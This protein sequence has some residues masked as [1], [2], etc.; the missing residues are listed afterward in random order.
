[1]NENEE[2]FLTNLILRIQD[3]EVQEEFV[4]LIDGELQGRDYTVSPNDIDIDVLEGEI[5][6]SLDIL[7]S[8]NLASTIKFLESHK[9]E[10]L[11][12]VFLSQNINMHIL[13]EHAGLIKGVP[14]DP[15]KFGQKLAEYEKRI[16]GCYELGGYVEYANTVAYEAE[17]NLKRVRARVAKT[18]NKSL[19]SDPRK[20]KPLGTTAFKKVGARD[21]Y[22]CAYCNS[23]QELE[24]DHI[25][26]FSRG[27]SDK[28][29][30]LQLLCKDCNREKGTSN[31]SD[32]VKKAVSVKLMRKIISNASNQSYKNSAEHIEDVRRYK[33]LRGYQEGAPL[34]KD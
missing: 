6:F 5:K 25:V 19:A 32:A 17:V 3:G 11:D 2:N 10:L 12:F 22:K 28:L 33:S 31:N 20:R 23:D 18:L 30:N 13:Y 21:G 29:D 4:E 16:S 15:L 27:G 14:A 8:N 7:Q 34:A 26:P 9:S 1:M 24:V